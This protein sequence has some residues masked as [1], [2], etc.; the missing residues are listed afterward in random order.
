[1]DAPRKPGG[2]TGPAPRRGRA[3]ATY[4]VLLSASATAAVRELPSECGRCAAAF[5]FGRLPA[6]PRRHGR[7]V[8]HGAEGAWSA[9][10]RGISV[11]YRI[12]EEERLIEV[13]EVACLDPGSVITVRPSGV[14]PRDRP[15]F[16]LA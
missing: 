12:V 4:T 5:V 15:G 9:T 8:P 11:R 2:P 13:F 7:A 14:R 10:W 1:M 16:G 6:S 3:E